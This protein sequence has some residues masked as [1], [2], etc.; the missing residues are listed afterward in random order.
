MIFKNGKD[1]ALNA[2]SG[3]LPDMGNAM[4]DYFQ[5]MTFGV[6]TKSVQGF[7]AVETVV[8]VDFQGVWQPL[9]ERQIQLKP[10]G[11]RAW[12]WFWLHS[13]PD[14]VLEVDDIITYL[15]VQYR[16]MSN[17]DYRLYNYVEYHLIE[18]FEGAGPTVAT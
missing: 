16:V 7:Q 9:T 5:K 11:Q 4:L 10:E 15:G 17:K 12:P 18:D 13:T 8:N 6:V 14:L 1:T 2:N 3:T